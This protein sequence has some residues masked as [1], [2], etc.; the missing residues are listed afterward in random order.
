MTQGEGTEKRGHR[1]QPFR[2]IGPGG[3]KGTGA[4]PEKVVTAQ[5]SHWELGPRSRL[6]GSEYWLCH[7]PVV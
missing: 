3:S 1:T 5:C 6:P 2:G 4:C 7:L